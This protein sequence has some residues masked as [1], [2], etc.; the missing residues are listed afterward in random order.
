MPLRKAAE[1]KKL[2]SFSRVGVSVHSVEEAK[3][4]KALGAAYV[5]AGHVFTTDCKPD[6]SPRGLSFLQNVCGAVPIPV[7]AI[8]GINET[9]LDSVLQAGADGICLM[10]SMMKCSDPPT[11][12]D[13]LCF[14]AEGSARKEIIEEK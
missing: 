11:Y 8:G 12:V 5:T 13:R 6:L 9:N 1:Y 7:F 3:Q 4:A 10:S 14:L 2:H